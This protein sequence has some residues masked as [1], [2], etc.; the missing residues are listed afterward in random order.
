MK[1]TAVAALILLLAVSLGT[2]V[3]LLMGQKKA[4][5]KLEDNNKLLKKS[6]DSEKELQ[7][8]F[9][10]YKNQLEKATNEVAKS[11]TEIS[12][13]KDYKQ[14]AENA[15]IEISKLQAKL[16]NASTA[17]NTI[18]TND[19]AKLEAEL[20]NQ[21]ATNET[22]K[23]ELSSLTNQIADLKTTLQK[24]EQ[25]EKDLAAFK[26][27]N[28][29]PD[30][31]LE[32]KKKRPVSLKTPAIP[33]SAPKLPGKLKQPLAFPAQSNPKPTPVPKENK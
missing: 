15:R 16:A 4:E 19:L 18:S 9:D 13:L 25:G 27:L 29:T 2:S 17:T 32:L 10:G 12:N 3:Y 26:E 7:G 22:T 14:K 31:I 23:V 28:M 1:K 30:E 5:T 24:T 33:K 20:V 6:G 11:K 21:K 8:K